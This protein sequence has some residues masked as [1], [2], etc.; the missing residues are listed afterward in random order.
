M[1]LTIKPGQSASYYPT[2]PGDPTDG[3]VN[4]LSKAD[5]LS[6]GIVN[7]NNNQI[8]LGVDST[9]KAQLIKNSQTVHG[10]N[11]VRLESVDTWSSGLMIADIVHMPGTA[12]GVW[13]AL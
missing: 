5:A 13:P 6:S 12:C 3:S 7:T 1:P 4:Y 9:N 2:Y 10:R 8:Y 11:S